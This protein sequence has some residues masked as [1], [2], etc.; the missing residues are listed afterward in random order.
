MLG[1]KLM[2]SKQQCWR[3]RR[4]VFLWK[5]EP[6]ENRE[7][8]GGGDWVRKGGRERER[9]RERKR[10]PDSCINELCSSW[11]PR[12]LPHC[13][14]DPMH[15]RWTQGLKVELCVCVCVRQCL[16]TLSCLHPLLSLAYVYLCAIVSVCILQALPLSI[17]LTQSVLKY[18]LHKSKSEGWQFSDLVWKTP[19]HMSGVAYNRCHVWVA[20][21][22][23]TLPHLSPPALH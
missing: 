21:R 18:Q 16:V 17:F 13:C 12:V 19:Y 15:S 22:A 10:E 11:R 14:A 5:C 1:V 2:K 8:R 9:E 20:M 6:V 23:F 3:V 4:A 7:G